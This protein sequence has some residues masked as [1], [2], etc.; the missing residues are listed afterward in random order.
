MITPSHS[1]FHRLF[2]KPSNEPHLPLYDFE[3]VQWTPLLRVPRRTPASLWFLSSSA[4]PICV[5]MANNNLP[6]GSLMGSVDKG[7]WRVAEGLRGRV[8]ED[9][10][11]LGRQ[12]VGV[13]CLFR[14]VFLDIQ[15]WFELWVCDWAC[16]LSLEI[17]GFFG[18]INLL[19]G[20]N[21]IPLALSVFQRHFPALLKW[22]AL[23]RVAIRVVR[24]YLIVFIEFVSCSPI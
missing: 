19:V 15:I 23:S 1:L 11:G 24:S 20:K 21:D 9:S 8:F 4:N 17:R 3:F 13:L 16:R 7:R 5:R 22:K 6:Q 10:L 2:L 12:M 14:Y 18:Q